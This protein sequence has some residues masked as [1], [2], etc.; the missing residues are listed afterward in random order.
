MSSS[1][2]TWWDYKEQE[3]LCLQ[4]LALYHLPPV[5]PGFAK[6]LSL[7]KTAHLPPR[8]HANHRSQGWLALAGGLGAFW[9]SPCYNPL[10]CLILHGV[11]AAAPFP[12]WAASASSFVSPS[13]E[14]VSSACF[15]L[16][17]GWWVNKIWGL[18]ATLDWIILE[19]SQ[20]ACSL[21]FNPFLD[22]G[23]WDSLLSQGYSREHL[24]KS[25]LWWPSSHRPAS[26]HL[27]QTLIMSG[28]LWP[29][30]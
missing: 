10:Q 25:S 13:S 3:S 1:R 21:D 30:G 5:L 19:P 29:C 22:Q 26:C 18:G 12:E 27:T 14:E 15:Q 23:G 6:F 2:K 20:S 24:R 8:L 28:S 9:K 7:A 17:W 16:T 4:Q 11:L